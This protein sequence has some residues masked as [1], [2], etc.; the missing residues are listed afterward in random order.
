MQPAVQ[1]SARP[2]KSSEY[3]PRPGAVHDI[4][5]F[6]WSGP[7]RPMTSAEKPMTRGVCTGRPAIS[8]GR[9]VDLTGRA[10]GRPK[11]CPVLNGAYL[12]ADVLFYSYTSSILR[13]YVVIW[14]SLFLFLLDSVG[15]LLPAMRYIRVLVYSYPL[16]TQFYPTDG[17][18][19]ATS[20]AKHRYRSVI[21]REQR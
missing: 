13:S 4:F 19:A 2:I 5:K 20:A 14:F 7:A 9:P 1:F 15:H 16:P 3:G 10:K 21:Q 11:C 12:F 18:A 6:S 8:V 17:P